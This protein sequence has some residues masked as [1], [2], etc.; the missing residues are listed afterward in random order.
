LNA[1]RTLDL[2]LLLYDDAVVALPG[3]RV[4]H[5]RLHERAFV[6]VPLTEIAP[7]A[8]H[9]VQKKTVAE[10]LADLGSVAG[11]RRLAAP[12]GGGAT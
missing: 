1:P 11:I 3:L 8:R 9:P 4:P 10:L 7:G 12:M 6:L 5:P 2:D